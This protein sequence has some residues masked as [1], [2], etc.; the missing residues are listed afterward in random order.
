MLSQGFYCHLT[1][2]HYD[3]KIEPLGFLPKTTIEPKSKQFI[4]HTCLF[5]VL[6]DSKDDSDRRLLCQ[7]D[8]SRQ[9]TNPEAA[10]QSTDSFHHPRGRSSCPTPDLLKKPP[11]NLRLW[12]FLT[13]VPEKWLF[14]SADDGCPRW[15]LTHNTLKF[16]LEVST[17]ARTQTLTLGNFKLRLKTRQQCVVHLF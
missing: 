14:I 2:T 8:A 9:V 3:S 10:A 6:T 11:F 5:F 16:F 12:S 4:S 7:E 17:L 1:R 15:E 13:N